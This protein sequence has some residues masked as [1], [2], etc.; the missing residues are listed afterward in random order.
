MTMMT[1]RMVEEYIR[2]I[3]VTYQ[4]LIMLTTAWVV[5]ILKY[6]LGELMM[7]KTTYRMMSLLMFAG[8]Y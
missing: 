3:S 6:A 4:Q 2:K 5:L 1:Q 7:L 8:K